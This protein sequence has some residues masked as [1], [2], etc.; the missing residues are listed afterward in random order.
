MT[1]LPITIPVPFLAVLILRSISVPVAIAIAILISVSMGATAGLAATFVVIL[2]VAVLL[3]V[4][5]L[6]RITLSTTVATAR[7]PRVFR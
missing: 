1:M 4:S 2:E 6:S 3:P 5:T 7:S